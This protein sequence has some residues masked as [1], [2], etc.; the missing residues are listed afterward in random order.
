MRSLFRQLLPSKEPHSFRSQEQASRLYQQLANRDMVSAM[1]EVNTI[2]HQLSLIDD[3]RALQGAQHL[4]TSQELEMAARA[5][6][7]Y[8]L[9]GRRPTI[10]LFR[11]R[12][13]RSK[14]HG[15]LKMNERHQSWKMREGN[16]D[17][18]L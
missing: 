4:A 13:Q 14:K 1:L 15:R 10:P 12:K 18:K 2:E 7:L 5:L 16:A 8:Y 6:L 11:E 9:E 17:N 3:R